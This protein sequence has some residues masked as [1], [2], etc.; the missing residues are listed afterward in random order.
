MIE[1]IGG[2]TGGVG[3]RCACDGGGGGGRRRRRRQLAVAHEL[4]DLVRAQSAL[5]HPHLFEVG[6]ERAATC[7]VA[8]KAVVDTQHGV[9]G[10][11]PHFARVQRRAVLVARELR[12]AAHAAGRE[13]DRQVRPLAVV[14][15]E[16]GGCGAIFGRVRDAV[17]EEDRAVRGHLELNKV[18]RMLEIGVFL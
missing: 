17:V 4:V 10:A 5:E 1:Q 16:V 11:A 8:A 12:P 18:D 9:N 3:E 6:V 14:E 7:R 2:N 15:A 13:R